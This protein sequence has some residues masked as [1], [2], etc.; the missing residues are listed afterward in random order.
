MIYRLH[1][2]RPA[3]ETDLIEF[4][5]AMSKAE[6]P[7]AAWNLFSAQLRKQGAKSTIYGF[8]PKQIA[9][10]LS[11]EI[12][13]FSNHPS[14]FSELYIDRGLIDH[15]P[16]ARYCMLAER[17]TLLWNDRRVENYATTLS[18]KVAAASADFGLLFGLTIPVSDAGGLRLGGTG[19]AIDTTSEKSFRDIIRSEKERLETAAMLFHA[20]V[21]DAAIMRQTIPLSSRELECLKWASTGL[22]NKEIAF[23]LGLSDKT[24]EFHMR[25][26]IRR[27]NARNRTH[28]VARALI[29][30]LIPV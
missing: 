30:G 13:A 24:V 22:V 27:L 23:R 28:A 25:N 18:Q 11:R 3:F 10:N 20:R 7:D 12:T 17:K 9:G 4:S 8:F 14:E 1:G 21:Q 26:A 15:D 2:T 29:Y 16:L 5:E 19:I 6:T